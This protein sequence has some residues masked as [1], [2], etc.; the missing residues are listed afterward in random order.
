MALPSFLGTKGPASIRFN[1]AGAMYPGPSA[2]K[3]GAIRTEIIGGGHKIAVFP[4][5]IRGAAAQF[6]LL[7]RLYTGMTLGAAINKWCGGNSPSTYLAV[8]RKYTGLTSSDMLTKEY[9]EDPGTGVPFARA[10]AH[11]EAGKPY[12]LTD[13]QWRE[14]HKLAFPYI[15]DDETVIVDAEPIAPPKKP[16][17]K[18]S[19]KWNL[20]QWLKGL[21]GIGATGTAGYSVMGTVQDAQSVMLPLKAF[22]SE[23]GVP[24]LIVVCVGGFVL[25]QLGQLFIQEDYEDGRYEPKGD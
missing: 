19:R 22:I 3:F 15:Y 8:V 24:V 12:P 23:W 1:N 11:H 9:L 4:D 25:S 14:A 18:A 7:H 21:F 10:M 20:L 2:R 5:A 16:V 17:P 6:D 13:A